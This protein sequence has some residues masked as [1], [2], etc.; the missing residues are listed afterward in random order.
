MSLEHSDQAFK[1]PLLCKTCGRFYASKNGQ[2]SKCY[3]A[4]ES[5]HADQQREERLIPERSK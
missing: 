3:A 1:R 2:C 4:D 5:D